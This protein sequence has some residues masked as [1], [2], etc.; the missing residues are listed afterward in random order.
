MNNKWIYYNVNGTRNGIKKINRIHLNKKQVK[1]TNKCYRCGKK[2]GIIC[3]EIGF[4]TEDKRWIHDLYSCEDCI[5]RDVSIILREQQRKKRK[6]E[7]KIEDLKRKNE[8]INDNIDYLNIFKY[9][10]K[11]YDEELKIEEKKKTTILH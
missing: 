9:H 2:I 11:E 6:N 1:E 5:K 3:Y 4:H 7:L 10:N 8:N